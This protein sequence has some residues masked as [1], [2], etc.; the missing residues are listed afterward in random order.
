MGG[1]GEE[2][3]AGKAGPEAVGTREE[4]HIRREAKIEDGE[5]V[6]VACHLCDVLPAAGN[7]AE[8]D[9]EAGDGAGHVERHL[10]DVGPDDGRHAAFKSVKKREQHDEDDGRDFAGAQDDGD[11]QRD[12]E[13]AYAFGEG[14]GHQEDGSGEF[15]DAFTETA[16]H[17][18]V[19]GEHFAA[20]VLRK[21][22]HRDHDASQ[23]VAE[24]DLEE[25][26]VAAEGQ[27]RR[28]DNGEGAGLG[29][30]DGKRDGPPGRRAA[31]QKVVAQV[32]LAAAKARAENRDRDQVDQNDCQIEIVHE[33]EST[34]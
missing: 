5:L 30:Y 14:T 27:G 18:F 26:E 6:S 8:N 19:G 23:Q 29:R 25:A 24:D 3:A 16:A 13:D 17:Q 34:S 21:E 12:G 22:E 10:H 7:L 2:A 28:A 33:C 1:G 20:E 15:A 4:F 32:F 11:H 31:S 9:D